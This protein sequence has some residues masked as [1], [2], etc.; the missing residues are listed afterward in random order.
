MDTQMVQ[1]LRQETAPF[2]SKT[3]CVHGRLID[4]VRT[5]SGKPTDKVRCLEC[6]VIFDDPYRS[7]D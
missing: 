2:A 5:K 4:D 6:G 7:G 1:E 3:L